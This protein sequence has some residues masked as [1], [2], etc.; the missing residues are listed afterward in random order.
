[1]WKK[2]KRKS[3]KTQLWCQA[4]RHTV[5]NGILEK[6]KG[7]LCSA[8]ESPWQDVLEGQRH[9]EDISLWN[10]KGQGENSWIE[11]KGHK[12]A[13]IGEVT[14]VHHSHCSEEKG[15]P[16]CQIG[17]PKNTNCTSFLFSC[18]KLISLWKI[19]SPVFL[20]K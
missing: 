20:V 14:G 12:P 5:W 7:G 2:E 1:M 10:N 9:D 17:R 11:R 18:L 15:I 4:S 8:Q 6:C 3:D 19:F 16:S 13:L